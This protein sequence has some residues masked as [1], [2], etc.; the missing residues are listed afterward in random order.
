MRLRW[1]L[2]ISSLIFPLLSHAYPHQEVLPEGARISLVAEKLNESSTLDG[3]RPT[4]QLFPP[5]STLKIVTALA[6]KLELG[7]SFAFRTK[8]E[9]SSSDAVIYFVGDPT[10]QT[11]DLKALLSLAKKNG[12]TRINGDLW[13][14]NSAFTGYDRAVGWPWDIL[15]VCYS[16]PASS[17]TLNNNCVQASIYTQKDGGTRV[18]VPEHQPIRVKSSVET[19]S[20]TIQKSRHCDLDLLANPDNHYELKGCLVERE[21]PLPLKFAVQDPERYTSQNISTLLKQLGI[22]LKGKIKIGSAPQKQRKLMALHQSKPLSDLLDDML[23]H[24]DNLIADT[25]TKTLGA[26]FFVQPGSFTNGTEAIKQ[27]IFANTGIDIRNARLEDGS[28]LSRNNRISATK[29]A[30]IL[31]YIWKNEKTLKLIAIMPK[32]GESGTLQYRQSMRNAPIKG[33]LIAKSG[34][35]YGTYNMAGYGLDKNGQ[36]NTIFVQFVSDYFPEKRDDNKPVIAPITH[37]EQLFYRDIV[38]FSQ[39]IPKK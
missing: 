7:D 22:E 3:I 12:L 34:S 23:K 10:L 30:E 11:Q 31:R 4:D 33:Q 8:L 24:S 14:D 15:G 29:M 19:V 37:F 39:A 6:A 21:K 2:L 32:S 28:G 25:L 5:A 26:K 9:T 27:I 35:L 17:I 18:Y 20:K 38:N 16:A 13:L 36:P 1:P